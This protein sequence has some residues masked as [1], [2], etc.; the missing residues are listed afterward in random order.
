[1]RKSRSFVNLVVCVA[2]A[3]LIA[4]TIGITPLTQSAMAEGND[5][6]GCD[7]DS[8]LQVDTLPPYPPGHMIVDFDFVEFIK[9]II[10]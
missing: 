3:L 5:P 1:M 10:L 4:G 7:D 6:G 2:V 8:C 9:S